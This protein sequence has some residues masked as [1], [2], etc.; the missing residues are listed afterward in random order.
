MGEKRLEKALETL[1]SFNDAVLAARLYP[2]TAPHA[3]AT[4]KRALQ[5]L[6]SYIGVYHQFHCGLVD[7]VPYIQGVPLA[8]EMRSAVG[9]FVIFSQLDLLGLPHLQLQ[10]DFSEDLLRQLLYIFTARKEKIT[11]EGGGRLFV[12]KM[13]LSQYFPDSIEGGQTQEQGVANQGKGSFIVLDDIALIPEHLVPTFLEDTSLSEK[14]GREFVELRDEQKLSLMLQIFQSILS[15]SLLKDGAPEVYPALTEAVSRFDKLLSDQKKLVLTKQFAVM[16]HERGSEPELFGTIL[17]QP[18]KNDFGLQL[19]RYL[20]D[21]LTPEQRF[22]LVELLGRQNDRLDKTTKEGQE[23]SDTLE[24]LCSSLKRSSL[25]ENTVNEDDTAGELQKELLILLDNPDLMNLLPGEVSRY[26]DEGD[27]QR[28]RLLLQLIQEKVDKSV[29]KKVEWYNG[30]FC[31]VTDLLIR[32]KQEALLF[33]HVDFFI[34]WLNTST[35]ADFFFEKY[36]EALHAIANYALQEGDFSNGL[37]IVRV[38]ASIRNG[39]IKKTVPVKAMAARIQDRM[40]TADLLDGLVADYL[41]NQQQSPAGPLLIALGMNGIVHL[42]NLLIMAE[43][44][45]V[46]FALIDLLE[47]AGPVLPSAILKILHNK[48]PWYAKRNLLQLL[49]K[50]G[51]STHGQRVADMA[52]DSDLRVQNEAIQCL[53][54]IGGSKLKDLLLQIVDFVADDLKRQVLEMLMVVSDEGVAAK[55]LDFLERAGG[56]NGA[57]S[58]TWFEQFCMV[59]GHSNSSAAYGRL[60]AFVDGGEQD[61]D[62]PGKAVDSAQQALLSLSLDPDEKPEELPQP[63]VKAPV[64]GERGRPEPLGITFLPQEKQARDLFAAG[65][66]E[67]GVE[68]VMDLISKMAEQRKFDQADKLREW[69]LRAAPMALIKAIQAAEIIQEQKTKAIDRGHLEV[70]SDLYDALSPEEF[71]TLY[72]SMQ[73]RRYRVGE[74]IIEQHTLQPALFFVNRGKVKLYYSDKGSADVLVRIAGPGDIVGVDTFFNASLW[75]ITASTMG[76]ADVSMLRL[77][78]QEKW[79]DEFP[80]LESKLHDFCL[81]YESLQE[82]F[83]N[84]KKD[85]RQSERKRIEGRVA[86]VLLDSKKQPTNVSA[87]GDLFDISRGGI[88]FFMRISVK[89]QAHVLLGQQIRT[90]LPASEDLPGKVIPVDGMVVAVRGHLVMENEYSVHVCF[91]ENLEAMQVKRFIKAAQS[92]FGKG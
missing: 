86:T 51:N 52:R 35:Q 65:K 44:K 68:L 87:K 39:E 9:D 30:A 13:G 10:L 82:F 20:I 29:D 38:F 63:E 27:M 6:S 79:Q 61:H 75:T 21:L 15:A 45:E 28:V 22:E 67:D 8:D 36:G 14:S 53:K 91:E 16:L 26:L 88:S 56:M 62:I 74:I 55:L 57:A 17:L 54:L 3:T 92:Q 1:E 5:D 76:P 7:S 89:D 73:H 80:A 66:E 42:L 72:H 77:E 83:K 24:N 2:V 33:D 11:R 48:L 31:L 23:L 18:M 43:K 90:L 25:D 78:S 81:Q 32:R 41:Q 70:W 85:R 60:K 64:D 49:G 50:T 71:S 34:H 4:F 37:K 84:T 69:L 12:E 59:L 47:T 46:R 58:K 40:V 19:Q